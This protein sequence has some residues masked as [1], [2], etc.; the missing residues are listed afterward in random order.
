MVLVDDKLPFAADILGRVLPYKD[1][2]MLDTID[3]FRDVGEFLH[4]SAFLVGVDR[5]A[6]Y[7]YK[8]H[9]CNLLRTF[10]A[11][12]RLSQ[13]LTFVRIESSGF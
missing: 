5:R 4:E 3:I 6:V 7:L 11:R 9:C 8:W 12:E 10:P 13:N 1:N 2:D